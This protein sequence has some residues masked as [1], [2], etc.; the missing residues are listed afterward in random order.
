[1]ATRKR[2]Y[3]DIDD[4][5]ESVPNA[6]IHAAV[7]SLSPYKKGKNAS[8][9]DGTLTD[10]TRKIRMIGFSSDQQKKLSSYQ[11]SQHPII[12]NNCEIK[13]SRQGDQYEILLKKFTNNI[14]ES[15]KKIEIPQNVPED[16][17]TSISVTELSQMQQ[18]QKVNLEI[19]VIK[20]YPPVTLV[21][22][23]QKQEVVIADSTGTSKLTLWEDDVDSLKENLCYA[24]QQVI[25]RQ[26]KD[27]P[28]YLSKTKSG[29]SIEEINDIG[30]CCTQDLEDTQ[31]Q[32]NE[33]VNTSVVAVLQFG[34]YRECLN[35]K[36]RV[37]SVNDPLGRCTKCNVLQ[38]MD[39]CPE[40]LSTKL[41]FE[42][43]GKSTMLHGFGGV[44]Q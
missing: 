4:F 1:M 16:S 17:S 24:L 6:S 23:K 41:L 30:V 25:V 42:T 39:R 35:C 27:S 18:F 33:L 38:R 44:L 10:G 43:N 15:P 2:L 3:E 29:S 31:N 19:R 40:Q 12:L 8:Y 7:M 28:K 34:A 11:E 5:D 13:Q 36:A 14:T 9:F 20:V 32:N 26:F 37:E 21:G 22:G